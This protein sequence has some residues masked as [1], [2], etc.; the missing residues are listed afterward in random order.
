MIAAGIKLD[1]NYAVSNCKL[2]NAANCKPA[3]ATRCNRDA[4]RPVAESN[5]ADCRARRDNWRNS[6]VI[7]TSNYQL[8]TANDC[9][10]AGRNPRRLLEAPQPAKL[11]A[12]SSARIIESD[13]APPSAND[14]RDSVI[15]GISRTRRFSAPPDPPAELPELSSANQLA[16]MTLTAVVLASERSETRA[17]RLPQATTNRPFPPA[18]PPPRSRSRQTAPSVRG[19][20][21]ECR[22]VAGSLS[23]GRPLAGLIQGLNQAFEARAASSE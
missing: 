12:R 3:L 2:I 7:T 15:N 13:V 17:H 22:R 20:G 16:V 11:A 18:A 6:I 14:N 10:S 19:A 1:R 5:N 21:D 9:E 8:I 4:G 23:E